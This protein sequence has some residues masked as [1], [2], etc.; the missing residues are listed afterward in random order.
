MS[1]GLCRLSRTPLEETTNPPACLWQLIRS[2][3]PAWTS[4]PSALPSLKRK[5]KIT[6][7]PR[8]D[9]MAQLCFYA[10]ASFK[11]WFSFVRSCLL[12]RNFC[13][14]DFNPRYLLDLYVCIYLY[15]IFF[16]N[17]GQTV[18]SLILFKFSSKFDPLLQA[19]TWSVILCH[20]LW[21]SNH[22]WPQMQGLMCVA[23][24]N[25]NLNSH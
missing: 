13:L 2:V 23:F 17:V 24:C 21:P 14:L 12:F 18:L 5:S 3:N 19:S 25:V 15:L 11:Y 22:A 4:L 20:G 16:L 6:S 7:P 8:L 10:V 1:E 9:Y